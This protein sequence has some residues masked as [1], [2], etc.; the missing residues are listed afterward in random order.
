M[1]D[2]IKHSIR[3]VLFLIAQAFIFNQL[4]IGFG[5]QLMVYPLYIFLLP[6]EMNVFLLMLVSFGLG[7]GIDLFSNTYGLHASSALI[8]AYGRPYLIKLFEPRDGFDPGTELTIYSMGYT[9]F[10]Y[11]F[12]TFLIAHTMWFFFIEQF[13]WSEFWYVVL[14]TVLGVP[15]SLFICVLLQFLFFKK[16]IKR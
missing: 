14:K 3:F 15:L 5:I 8:I 7:F 10:G 4:E 16:P 2:I 12:G 6:L 9:W 1:I 13:K 11:V